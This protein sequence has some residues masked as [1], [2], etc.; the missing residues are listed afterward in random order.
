MDN[1]VKIKL[2]LLVRLVVV[3]LFVLLLY[4]FLITFRNFLYPVALAIMLAYL[5]YPLAKFFESKGVP[6]IPAN[7]LAIIAG[8]IVLG[9][10]A[11][12][13]Y[14]RLRF[15]LDDFPSLQQKALDNIDQ[16]LSQIGILPDQ[17][18]SSLKV[19]FGNL[20]DT[21]ADSLLVFLSSTAQTVFTVFIMP[22][23]VFFLLYYRNKYFYFLMMIIAPDNHSVAEKT[24]RDVS[25]VV[26]RY[27][28][29]VFLVVMILCVVNSVGLT[30]I[31][32]K[33]PVLLGIIAAIWNFIP[34]FGTIIGYSFPLVMALITGDGPETAVGVA[35]LF[36]IV[37][38]TEN[39]I[40]T[41]NI[42]GGHVRVNPF[43]VILGV[44]IGGVVWGIPG[45]FVM[46]PTLAILR[47][48]FEN[49]P[50]LRP[51]AYL[52]GDTGTEQYAASRTNISEF[53]RRVFG[54][55]SSA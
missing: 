11:F 10:T 19:F 33:F 32:L 47:I 18:E 48:T 1:D 24:I 21:S 52:I 29:G 38:F 23:Y 17:Q 20:L 36:V 16:I 39:N 50:S 45:M 55:K 8:V 26:K 34:Y 44:L 54:K 35:V 6:R 4:Y 41:P 53:F 46:V 51:W 22:V 3:M 28:T 25:T 31:G 30:I 27:M 49:I 42:T 2:P 14:N 40:L 37:Q 7:L 5:L 15:L 43:F 13:V 9:G 12:F